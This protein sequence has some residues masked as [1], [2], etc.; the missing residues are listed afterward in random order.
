MSHR[1]HGG[2]LS[3][4]QDV[5][6]APYNTYG[7]PGRAAFLTRVHTVGELLGACEF[8]RSRSLRSAV[9]GAGSNVV[10]DESGYDGLLIVNRIYQLER[11]DENR[12]EVGAGVDLAELVGFAQ[13]EGLSGLERLAGI[14]GS[15]GGAL[16]GNAGAFGAQIG[17]LVEKVEY[18]DPDCR[19]RIAAS[20]ELA[21][22]YRSSAFKRGELSGVIATA[23]LRMKSASPQEIAGAMEET[24]A[25]R[26][27]K[28]PAGASCGSYFKNVE[29]DLLEP[30]VR[31]RLSSWITFDRIPAGRLIEE[32]GGKGMRVG[33]AAVSAHHCNFLLNEGNATGS[34]VKQLAK[35][36]KESVR[37]R[38]GIELEEEVRYL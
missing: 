30:E 15:V 38:F 24:L 20:A 25:A 21:F 13:R 28:H 5:D 17:E 34:E 9:L 31:A 22:G 36:I 27:G 35:Q 19:G 18:V 1:P 7:L 26:A 33:G 6:L 8:A 10:L 29:A 4:E 16:F 32:A 23:L 11:R 14:P 12:I 2:S 3:V 37:D